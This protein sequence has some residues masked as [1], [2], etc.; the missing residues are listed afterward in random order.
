MTLN[1]SAKEINTGESGIRLHDADRGISQ[2]GDFILAAGDDGRNHL[3]RVTGVSKG[4]IQH[5]VNATAY[6]DM[7]TGGQHPGQVEVTSDYK[8]VYKLPKGK[9]M[10]LEQ[11]VNRHIER[12]PNIHFVWNDTGMALQDL[13][14]ALV[15]RS[16]QTVRANPTGI[17]PKTGGAVM[18]QGT[19][20]SKLD[21]LRA[22][23]RDILGIKVA[24]GP[25]SNQNAPSQVGDF[26]LATHDNG[27]NYLLRV[28]GASDGAI[29][30]MA[31]PSTYRDLKSGEIQSDAVGFGQKGW[32]LMVAS[33]FKSVDKLPPDKNPAL[34]QFINQ[35]LETNPE[36]ENPGSTLG[37]S[38]AKT[39]WQRLD[40]VMG[41][42]RSSGAMAKSTAK[43]DSVVL[44]KI[45][46]LSHDH[47][48]MSEQIAEIHQQITESQDMSPVGGNKVGLK[49]GKTIGGGDAA[50][51]TAA[52]RS[53]GGPRG[54]TGWQ[55]VWPYQGQYQN[56]V[57]TAQGFWM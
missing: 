45:A 20:R 52:G 46:A 24:S 14:N 27:T 15:G 10:A 36:K 39:A 21:N 44:G 41:S 5:M 22:T 9:R 31:T 19:V 53:R 33:D 11:F 50:V 49:A 51:T 16:Q 37:W 57:M 29:L 23:G 30:H 1:Y 17:A 26:V 13:D 32:Q 34:E 12:R 4:K 25:R 38:D 3:L 48:K 42:G 35:Y 56:G 18:S 54:A 6:H 47:V 8:A 55:T 28:T 43:K 2:V 7:K 40:K